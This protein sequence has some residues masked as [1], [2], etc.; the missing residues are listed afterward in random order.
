MTDVE[1]SAGS[2]ADLPS[3]ESTAAP[4]VHRMVPRPRLRRCVEQ[5]TLTTIQRLRDGQEHLRD[6]LTGWV[7]TLAITALAFVVRLVNLGYP[8]NLVFDETYYAKDGWTI[9]K[10]GYE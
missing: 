8:K 3:E 1:V 4:A 2:P 9:W 7:V 10:Y 5:P 6:R